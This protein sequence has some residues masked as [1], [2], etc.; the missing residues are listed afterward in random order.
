MKY[1]VIL[2]LV[3]AAGRIFISS[4]LDSPALVG[5]YGALSHMV[6]G[7]LL[8][9]PFY[10]RKE[11]VGQSILYGIFGLLLSFWEITWYLNFS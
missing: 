3:V 8:L 9:V 11:E 5:S 4:H 7:F 2:C 10:D 6:I 1:V